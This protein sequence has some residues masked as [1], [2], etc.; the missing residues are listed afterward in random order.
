MEHITENLIISTSAA[1]RYKVVHTFT[2]SEHGNGYV[3]DR[4]WKN[5]GLAVS[6]EKLHNLPT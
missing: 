5:S 1:G 6:A 3:F 2:Y 4:P